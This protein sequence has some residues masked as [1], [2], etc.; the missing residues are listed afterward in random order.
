[1][2]AAPLRILPL[3]GSNEVGLNATLYH[4]GADGL[5][6]D[7][8]ALLGDDRSPAIQRIVPSVEPLLRDQRRIHGLVLT[9]G[10]EDHIGAVPYLLQR[11]EVPVYGSPLALALVRSRLERDGYSVRMDF[12]ELNPGTP[13][14]IGPFEVEP[15]AVTH[16][17]PESSMIAIRSEQG[18]VVHTG[19]FKLDREPVVGGTDVGRLDALADEGVDLLLSDSTNAERSGRSATETSVVSALSAAIA[20][21]E[22]R[23]AVTFVSS[24]LHR[25]QA[26]ADVAR[27]L[28]RRVLLLGSAFERNREIAARLGLLELDPEVATV[29]EAAAR[30][31]RDR[32]LIV[33]TGSQ[34]EWA[35]AMARLARGEGPVPL[36]A[37][38]R[39]IFSARVIPGREVAVRAVVNRLVERGVEVIEAR[40]ERALHTS[41]HAQAE[42]QAELIRRLRPRSFA[43]IHGDRVMLNAHA[44]T[45]RE[46]GMPPDEIFVVGDGQSLELAKG[47]VGRGDAEDAP[48]VA[49]D[50]AGDPLPWPTVRARQT[51]AR[52]GVLACT[53]LVD[54]RGI[55]AAL[56]TMVTHGFD[57]SDDERTELARGVRAELEDP[58]LVSVDRIR[59]RAVATLRRMLARSTPVVLVQVLPISRAS[60]EL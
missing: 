35:G 20:E 55:T 31:P 4:Q 3:G 25:L 24:H 5:L 58:T 16:S 44:A 14:D 39:V 37:G 41:G 50:A 2:T 57:L 53:V 12:R 8:G 6:V 45:A 7:F 18:L 21:A 36:E 30:L 23:V 22:G 51:L 47:Q 34:G 19:D 40:R 17:I 56:P 33:A 28:G 1:M 13:A 46:A 60:P 15:I 38:D 10:H 54:D 26:L 9:H 52:Q 59:E 27:R 49:L 32:L 48:R 42:E 29:P 11:L 43:P